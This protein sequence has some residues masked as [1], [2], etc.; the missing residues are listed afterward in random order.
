VESGYSRGQAFWRA[1]VRTHLDDDYLTLTWP[2]PEYFPIPRTAFATD[3]AFDQFATEVYRLIEV[4]G[5][6]VGDS[7]PDDPD[8]A[9]PE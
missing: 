1:V 9:V 4:S 6:N 8:G 3:A 5:G 7:P 2:G